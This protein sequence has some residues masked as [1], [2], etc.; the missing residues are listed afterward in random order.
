VTAT[1]QE[2]IVFIREE[3]KSMNF[4]DNKAAY[5]PKDLDMNVMRA[6][7]SLMVVLPIKKEIKHDWHI[8]ETK[9]S[10]I[11]KDWG[12]RPELRCSWQITPEDQGIRVAKL[13]EKLNVH[14]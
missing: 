9:I 4:W 5:K 3:R 2:W 12:I 8:I 10:R 6:V 11:Q 14:S 13:F 7:L 1:E